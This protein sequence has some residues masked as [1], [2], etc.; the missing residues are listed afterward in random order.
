MK[1]KIIAVFV[2]FGMGCMILSGCEKTPEETI[3]RE[4]GADS[5]KQYESGENAEGDRKSVV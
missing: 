2:C 4:K 3:V 5:I 1:K